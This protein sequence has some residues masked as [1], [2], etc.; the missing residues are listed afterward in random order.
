MTEGLP[1][2][3][4]DVG[5]DVEPASQDVLLGAEAQQEQRKAMERELRSQSETLDPSARHGKHKL[6]GAA[7]VRAPE[8]E[9]VRAEDLSVERLL[10]FRGRPLLAADGREIGP[11]SDIYLDEAT[12]I[13]EWLGAHVGSRMGLHCVVAPV[14]GAYVLADAISVPYAW[15]TVVRATVQGDQISADEEQDLYRHFG[16]PWSH[17]R[18]PTGLPAGLD[19]APSRLQRWLG[20]IPIPGRRRAASVMIAAGT[21]TAIGASV[22][23]ARRR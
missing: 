10:S 1:D 13:P 22:A 8:R 7:P 9:R 15:D 12:S 6:P 19:N 17:E 21:L 3:V 16:V 23:I 11:I 4:P 5:S 14:F 18:S 20:G 2:R